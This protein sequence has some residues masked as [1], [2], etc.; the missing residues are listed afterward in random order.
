MAR[1]WGR[2]TFGFLERMN[3]VDLAS[4]RDELIP[5]LAKLFGRYQISPVE[6]RWQKQYVKKQA[7][8]MLARAI[9]AL[10]LKR[11]KILLDHDARVIAALI[12]E[13]AKT[14][15]AIILCTC[16]GGHPKTGHIGSL[17]NRP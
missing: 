9:D 16:L 6:L 3:R 2:V 8:E 11:P 13:G 15:R 1:F 12:D 7:E 4:A 5:K 14:Q 17:Q 10:A